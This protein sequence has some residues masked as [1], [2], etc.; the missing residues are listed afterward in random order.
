MNSLNFAFKKFVI[1]MEPPLRKGPGKR[2]LRGSPFDESHALGQD[3]ET[4]L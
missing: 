1:L 2:D 4:R 3:C